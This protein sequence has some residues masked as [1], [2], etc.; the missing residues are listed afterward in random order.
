MKKS[1]FFTG[2]FSFVTLFSFYTFHDKVETQIF[3][4]ENLIVLAQA[5]TEGGSGTEVDCNSCW[6][7]C[8]FGC[9]TKYRC[10][11]LSPCCKINAK[12]TCS[13]GVADKCN[14]SAGCGN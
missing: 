5:Q 12:A 2:I 1:I 13:N 4:L 8:F 6:L 10:N 11:V 3:N 9:V 7:D 14:T